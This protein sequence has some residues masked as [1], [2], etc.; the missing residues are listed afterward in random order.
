MIN[1]HPFNYKKAIVILF[2]LT[3]ILTACGQN[4]SRPKGIFYKVV[5]GYNQMHILG[6]VHLGVED[7][8]PL[9]GTIETAFNTA[10]TLVVEANINEI[11]QNEIDRVLYDYAFYQDGSNLSDYIDDETLSK[12]KEILVPNILPQEVILQIKPWYLAQVLTQLA[13]QNSK[14]EFQYGVDQY[15]LSKA[16]SKEIIGL[17]TIEDQFKPYAEMDAETNVKYLKMA[18][19]DRDKM[20]DSLEELI[21]YWYNGEYDTIETLR[22]EL[23]NSIDTESYENYITALL[24]KRDEQIAKKLES[25]LKS[26]INKQYFVVIGYMHLA[27]ENSVIDQLEKLG[28]TLEIAN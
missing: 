6:S 10:S 23:K 7:M 13:Q 11:S 3:L 27:G 1:R 2:I 26:D 25:L 17:E 12:V 14:Y 4:E 5:G 8:Y 28:Y 21:D 15:F 19:E 18:L 16:S 9:D 22:N 24:D 20:E